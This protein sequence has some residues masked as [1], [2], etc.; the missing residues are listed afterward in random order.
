MEEFDF[1]L[2]NDMGT[3]VSQ[4]RS[5]GNNLNEA[6]ENT[7]SDD[8]DYDKVMEHFNSEQNSGG[9]NY[10]TN[11]DTMINTMST[12]L[13][14]DKQPT[15]MF[16]NT[17]QPQNIPQFVPEHRPKKQQ[18]MNRFVRDLETNLDNFG[19]VNLNEPLP[20][21]FTKPMMAKPVPVFQKQKH[22][23]TMA[24]ANVTASATTKQEKKQES[25]KDESVIGRIKN[26]FN[27]IEFREIIICM[28][29]FMVLNN[30]IVIE[31]I[32]EKIPF[33]QQISSPYP[34][35]ILRTIIFGLILILIKKF[36]L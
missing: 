17:S 7:H 20:V 36:N 16:T 6:N 11:R 32:Y 21:N 1:D 34:N 3:S 22:I 25:N 18:N 19:R 28:L 8:F 4:L 26:Y 15:E 24:N 27:K 2:N 9:F 23:E 33:M 29:L 35:L 14:T 30:K 31:L 10:D 12:T 5:R 13:A